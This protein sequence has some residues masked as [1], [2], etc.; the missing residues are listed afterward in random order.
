MWSAHAMRPDYRWGYNAFTESD[1]D[2]SAWTILFL[3]ANGWQVS[4]HCLTALA[5]F[6]RRD[7]GF[8]TFRELSAGD[9][10]LDSHPDVTPIVVRAIRELGASDLAETSRRSVVEKQTGMGGWNSFWWTTP[11]YSTWA[12]LSLVESAGWSYD[13]VRA[14]AWVREGTVNETA[15]ERALA[16]RASA[17]LG[18]VLGVGPTRTQALAEAICLSQDEDGSWASAPMLRLTAARAHDPWTR[19]EAG[20]VYADTRRTFTTA[21]VI[22]ALRETRVAI[23]GASRP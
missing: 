12:N 15:F 17:L 19:A 11:W 16:L 21:T 1:A 6:R 23:P 22:A 7:G 18:D 5:S 8:A 3:R 20:R 9:S 13:R 2:T 4:P 14:A 10:W